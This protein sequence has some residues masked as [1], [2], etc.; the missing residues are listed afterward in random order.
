MEN[1]DKKLKLIFYGGVGMV[2][3]ANFILEKTGEL[4]TKKNFKIMIDCGLVQGGKER[5][6]LNNQPF[7]YNPEEIDFL[8]V[9]HSHLD[10]IGR[11]PKLIKDGFKGKIYSNPAT[12]DLSYLI[13]EDALKIMSYNSNEKD[14]LYSSKDVDKTISMWETIDYGVETKFNEGFSVLLKDAGHIL[15]SSIVEIKCDGKSVAFTGDLGNSPSPIIRDTESVKGVDYIVMESVYGDRNHEGKE[16]RREKLK[17]I[18][19]KVIQKKG[20]LLIPT[21]SVEKTQIILSELNSLIENKEVES[22]PVFLDSP[23]AIKATEVYKKYSH[24]FNKESKE[25]INSGDDIF[26]F[27]KLKL[28]KRREESE[29][30]KNTPNP[31]IILAGSGMS[32]GGRVMSHEIEYLSDK[33]TTVLFTGFQVAGTLGRQ[34]LDGSRNVNIFDNDIEVRADVESIFS[35]SSHKDSDHLLEFVEQAGEKVKKVFVV[36]GELKAGLF[37]VQKVRDNLDLDA[38]YP[39]EGESFDL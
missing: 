38:I 36:M 22:I 26:N 34:I 18:I 23:L 9:T 27:P 35:Y 6:K 33:S 37:F 13:F 4:D 8:F 30:I 19:K 21:F 11:I 25:T 20:T 39:K 7:K 32:M 29:N 2:T 15:G 14:F 3:G 24:Y 31:K 28:T 12:K 5:E 10:H 17:G 1:T 16:T